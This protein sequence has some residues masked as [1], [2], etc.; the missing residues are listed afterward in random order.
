MLRGELTIEYE[1]NSVV[2]KENDFHIVP[3]GVLHNPH[4]EEECWVALVETMSTQH[5]GDI[6]T[7]QTKSIEAQL[8]GR[9]TT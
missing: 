7:E 4:T 5:T 2:L 1:H 3:R 6:V 8:S 9:V